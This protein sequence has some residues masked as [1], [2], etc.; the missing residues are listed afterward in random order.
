[1]RSLSSRDGGRAGAR[2][3]GAELTHARIKVFN[4]EKINPGFVIT[5]L[6]QPCQ[7]VRT[8]PERAA[9]F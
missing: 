2:L 3:T 4:V 7:K 8:H 9:G 5:V 1:M 6:G